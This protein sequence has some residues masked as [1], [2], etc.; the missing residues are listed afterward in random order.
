MTTVFR[1]YALASKLLD[2]PNNRSSHSEP[3]PRGGGVAIVVAFVGAVLVYSWP[4]EDLAVPLMWLLGAG[5]GSALLGF[6]DD[7]NHIGFHWRLLMHFLFA[8]CVVVG[9]GGLP[10]IVI[11]GYTP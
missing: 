4:W 9:M 8:Y 11:L 7:H 1:R 2:I 5:A 3:T 6:H 10:G